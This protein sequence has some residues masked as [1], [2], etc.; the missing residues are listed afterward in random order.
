MFHPLKSGLLWIVATK[1]DEIHETLVAY[2]TAAAH[3]L[4][5]HQRAI[6][7]RPAARRETQAQ[8]QAGH[9]P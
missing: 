8:E 6:G 3:N 4:F 1:I 5:A 9:L 7:S 2:S